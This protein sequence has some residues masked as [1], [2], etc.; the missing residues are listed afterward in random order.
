MLV[1]D[2]Q[3][4]DLSTSVHAIMF[5]SK[6]LCKARYFPDG[7]SKISN[8]LLHCFKENVTKAFC[9]HNKIFPLITQDPSFN[10]I[11]NEKPN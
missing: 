11:R 10:D 2:T 6:E 5:L 9:R 7:A 4:S 8:K 1:L 3:D